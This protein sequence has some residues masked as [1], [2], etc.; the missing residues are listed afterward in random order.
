M[1]EELEPHPNL[2]ILTIGGFWGRCFPLWLSNSALEKLVQINITSCEKC[3]HVPQLGE[4]RRLKHLSLH[5]LALVEYII[6][7]DEQVQS[8]ESS[9]RLSVEY[10]PS[11]KRLK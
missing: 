1:L 8:S 4:L 9:N 11:L 6:Q 5:N 2:E 7:D 10:F 3:L